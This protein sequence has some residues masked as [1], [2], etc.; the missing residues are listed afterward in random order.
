MKNEKFKS[1]NNR[2][3]MFKD[4]KGIND[5][6]IIAI[7]TFIFFATALIIPFINSEFGTS[8][9]NLDTD[10]ITGE[11]KEGAGSVTA[12]SAFGILTTVL[13]L[14]FFDFGNTLGLPF[15]LDAIYTVIAILF[16]LVIA[17]NIWV[18]GGG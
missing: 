3:R 5:I 17:R 2:R 11:I 13:K 7:F 8:S 16:I 15:W 12:I 14:A 4:K 10:S 9:S 1:Y 18:G 6:S